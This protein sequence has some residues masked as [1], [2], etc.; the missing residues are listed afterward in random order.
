MPGF[1]V[2]MTKDHTFHA[3]VEGSIEWTRDRFTENKRR[4][5][6]LVPMEMPNTR[7]AQPPP[8]MYHPEL[9][10]EFAERNPTNLEPIP[11]Y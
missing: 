2:K 3:K 5:L 8:F 9:L 7:F 11:I 10:P 1:H 4:R 6:H